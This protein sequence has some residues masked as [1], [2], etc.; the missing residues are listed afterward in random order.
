MDGWGERIKADA[1]SLSEVA[2]WWSGGVKKIKIFIYLIP[3]DEWLTG[4]SAAGV[5]ASLRSFLGGILS[6]CRSNSTNIYKYISFHSVDPIL[7]IYINIFSHSVDPILQIYI[8]IYP[9]IQ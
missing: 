3:Q 1:Q 4:A 9:F 6:F 7:E 8:N 2:F 5:V